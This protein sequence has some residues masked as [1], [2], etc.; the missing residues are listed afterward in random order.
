MRPPSKIDKMIQKIDD[1]QADFT[2]TNS[3]IEEKI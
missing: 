3:L 2:K 1:I